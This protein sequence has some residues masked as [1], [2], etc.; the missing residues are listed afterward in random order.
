MS[1]RAFLQT[2][3][4]TMPNLI[5]SAKETDDIIAYLLALKGE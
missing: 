4:L 2:P 1:L 3:H 5:L